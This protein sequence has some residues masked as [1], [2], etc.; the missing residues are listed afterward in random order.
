ML[1][2]NVCYPRSENQSA[3]KL[4][5]KFFILISLKQNASLGINRRCILFR[6]YT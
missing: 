2:E 5:Q 4:V 6:P 3:V 1:F